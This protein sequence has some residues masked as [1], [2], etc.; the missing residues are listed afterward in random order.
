MTNKFY[1]ESVTF[2]LLLKEESAVV[3]VR[4]YV[5]VGIVHFLPRRVPS[6]ERM[7]SSPVF[8]QTNS[9]PVRLFPYRFQFHGMATDRS[10]SHSFLPKA[11]K[12]RNLPFLERYIPADF[13]NQSS[14]NPAQL[15]LISFPH[16]RRPA[17]QY[18]G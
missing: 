13:T 12:N 18:A 11:Y 3:M 7:I 15:P 10:P 1:C 2:S 16:L 4:S 6:I 5:V 17:F 8:L 9:T 14:S